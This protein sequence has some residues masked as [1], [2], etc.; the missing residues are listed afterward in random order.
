[1]DPHLTLKS[2]EA[3]RWKERAGRIGHVAKG[4]VYMLSGVLT[5]LAA[6]NI[7]GQK[8]GKTEVIDFLHHQ[9]LGNVLLILIAIGLACYAFWRFVESFQ[10]TQDKG[11][12][13]KGKAMRAG[14]F[15]SGLLYLGLAIYT[16]MQ[17]SGGSSGS[18]NSKQG[19]VATLLQSDFGVL[20]VIF[21][22]MGFFVKS[23]YQFYRVYKGNFTRNIRSGEL[24][25]DKAET[26]VRNAGY[27][28]Y[29]SR[30]IVIGII[31]YFFLKAALQSDAS[32]VQ[33]S[34]GAF[35]F[36]QQSATGAWLL[37]LVAAGLVCYGIFMLISARY[38]NFYVRQ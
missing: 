2:E 18:G 15:G 4:I 37:A 32:E 28:G 27:A 19:I 17:I 34:T 22:A 12:D 21:I 11:S 23:I 26:I 16:V 36:L 14:Y 7:G 5:L 6:L 20:V 35:S 1:M 13:A 8:A 25:T 30:G 24:P 10:D 31:G 33:G 38:K 29:I 3:D 9:P